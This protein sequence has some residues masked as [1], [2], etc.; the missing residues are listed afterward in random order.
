MDHPD[1]KPVRWLLAGRQEQYSHRFG[2]PPRLR[3]MVPSGQE[4]PLHLLVTLDLADPFL[5]D[6]GQ[7]PCRNLP[8]V[9]QLRYD[10][11]GC[12]RYRPVADDAIEIKGAA[13]G[14]VLS[15]WPT[16]NYPLAFPS[17]PLV[18]HPVP[19]PDPAYMEE[20]SWMG[21]EDR[22]VREH[23]MLRIQIGAGSLSYQCQED[24]PPDCCGPMRLICVV[25]N[26]PVPDVC[27]W[28]PDGDFVWILFWL[29]DR[30][31]TIE[32]H[33]ECD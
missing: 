1:G 32:T 23:Q 33:N 4:V 17:T 3:G 30:C 6:F 2:G 25:P 7:L 16:E 14:N 18:V 26:R 11:W 29:C 22:V 12:L 20:H 27:L 10:R 8:L 15:D 19:E 28:G 5:R 9:H 24:E 31:K 21:D 13:E